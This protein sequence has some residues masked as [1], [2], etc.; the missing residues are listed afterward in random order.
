MSSS[1]DHFWIRNSSRDK[2]RYQ[3]FGNIYQILPGL[4][5]VFAQGSNCV[6]HLAAAHHEQIYANYAFKGGSE[7]KTRLCNT[8]FVKSS[9]GVSRD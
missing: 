4:R 5:H 3:F 9:N 1:E 2:S 7:S 8:T 6:H